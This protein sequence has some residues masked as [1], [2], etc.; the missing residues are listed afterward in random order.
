VTVAFGVPVKVTVAFPP[1]QIVTLA[2]IETV[3]GGT[4]VMVIV[5]V[6]G[7]VQAGAPAVVMLTNV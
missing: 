7:R 2:D 5:P 6:T 4:T 1:G 3:G